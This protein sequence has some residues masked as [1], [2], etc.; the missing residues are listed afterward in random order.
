MKGFSQ[1]N[2][3]YMRA[4]AQSHPDEQFVQQVAAQIPW[5]HGPINRRWAR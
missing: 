2:L 5:G 1:R 4:F 3:K